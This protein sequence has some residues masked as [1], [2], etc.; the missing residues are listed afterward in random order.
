MLFVYKKNVFIFFILLLSDDSS[1]AITV[2][3][4]SALNSIILINVLTASFC[5]ALV[6]WQWCG[7]S[8]GRH[9]KWLYVFLHKRRSGDKRGTQL[10]VYD[11][12]RLWRSGML[13]ACYQ[14]WIPGYLRMQQNFW[15]KSFGRPYFS[16][17]IGL[18]NQHWL[19]YFI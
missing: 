1:R 14:K 11:P 3:S 10:M 18:F 7:H 13:Q 6:T 17:R 12:R 9:C 2:N 4:A 16:S 15:L 19:F 8:P 5:V